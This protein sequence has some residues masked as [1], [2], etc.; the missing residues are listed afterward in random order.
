[1][2]LRTPDWSNRIISGEVT[3]R[4]VP[5]R[6]DR[7]FCSGPG[8]DQWAGGIVHD[9]GAIEFAGV[10]SF[11]PATASRASDTT[12]TPRSFCTETRIR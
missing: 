6:K 4:S 11:Q 3:T 9:P 8:P 12:P 2:Q 10:D 1:M 5:A 7:Q